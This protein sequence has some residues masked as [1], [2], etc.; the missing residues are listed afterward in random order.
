[1][2]RFNKA[3]PSPKQGG[4]H[5][6]LAPVRISTE[7]QDHRSLTDQEDYC[8]RWLDREYPDGHE[9]D[10]LSSQ[11]SGEDVTSAQFLELTA[12][13]ESGE[14]DCVIAEDLS[15]FAR[16]MHAFLLCEAAED[17]GTR[18][19][20]INDSVDTLRDDWRQ[21]A[22][23]AAFKNEASNSDTSKRIRRSLRA[24]FM[25]GQLPLRLIAGYQA[26]GGSTLEGDVSKSPGASEIYD[27]WF[28]RLETDQSFAEIA[29]W[30]NDIKFPVG[31]SCGKVEWDGTLV[32]QVTRNP[33]LKGLRQRNNKISVRLNKTGKRKSVPA[34]PEEL[35]ER[36][37][38]HLMFIEPDRYGRVI[39]M[40]NKRNAKYTKGIAEANNGAKRSRGTRNDSR[41]PSQHTCCGICGR[42]YVLGG[43]GNKDRMMC[44]G[45]R[46]YQCW[47]AMTFNQAEVASRVAAE[48]NDRIETL[49][50]FDPSLVRSV[51]EESERL[52]GD[53]Q[54]EL[55]SL[56][57]ERS[58][59]AEQI[60]RLTTAIATAPS[61]TALLDR[62]LKNEEQIRDI[63]DKI[64]RV[65]AAVPIAPVL[66]TA[67]ELRQLARKSFLK[68]AVDS[69]E[70]AGIMRSIVREF[71]VLP[72]RLIDGGHIF[73]RVV[74]KLSLGGVEG[75]AVP[76]RLDC[77]TL[78][79]MVDL[80]PSPQ[81][82]E[83]R[84]RVIALRGSG[85]K[86]REVADQLGI[87]QTAVQ[88]A[89]KLHREMTRLGVSDPWQPVLTHDDAA[90][91]FKRISHP[92]FCFK[93]LNGFVSKF[94]ET[95]V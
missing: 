87:T 8:R 46:S 9:L 32:G 73:P 60:E 86:E 19:V 69:R 95:D 72:Y 35:L 26:L 90:S 31:P 12:R 75:V 54:R 79:C 89:A 5:R 34:P 74:F 11:V 13:V 36:E 93:P 37:V 27:E 48:I 22:V 23:F 15:R 65:S 76:D 51:N 18:L 14:Y 2:P 67:D 28:T 85:L 50:D 45:A 53:G 10:C 58:N 52:A 4:V 21:S 39:R 63:D 81:R 30:L 62:L 25:S 3:L 33:L 55:K 94:P 47:N 7:H 38:P 91:Y 61:S 20:A 29:I 83:F 57:K 71:Y 84:E 92:R 6:I 78:R 80:T 40:L 59:I 82:V 68:L 64:L 1:M 70:F 77:M 16:R 49:P 17:S 43:H 24:R 42:K 66:P 44:D 56:N 41:W 88:R